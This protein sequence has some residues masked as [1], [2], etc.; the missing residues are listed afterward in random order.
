MSAEPA[1]DLELPVEPAPPHWQRAGSGCAEP[2]GLEALACTAAEILTRSFRPP[3]SAAAPPASLA[4]ALLAAPPGG[5][6]V[7]RERA[8]AQL[9]ALSTPPFSPEVAALPAGILP[10]APHL[11]FSLVA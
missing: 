7:R 8:D 2:I 6:A 5:G 11:T 4:A 1:A 3:A 9:S 10:Q